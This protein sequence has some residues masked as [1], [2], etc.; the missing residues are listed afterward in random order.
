M[1]WMPGLGRHLDPAVAVLAEG[2]LE[3]RQHRRHV[4]AD[5]GDVARERIEDG[6]ARM[7]QSIRRGSVEQGD[8]AWRRG[9]VVGEARP[10][11]VVVV[12]R[13]RR[14]FAQVQTKND[15]PAGSSHEA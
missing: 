15:R 10:V 8:D 1:V 9:G 4:E 5:R 6:M 2:L 11:P 3:S 14:R 7:S 12:R 13:A